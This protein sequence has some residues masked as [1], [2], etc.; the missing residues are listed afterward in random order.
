MARSGFVSE[1]ET[2]FRF[3][4]VSLWKM[5]TANWISG[6]LTQTLDGKMIDGGGDHTSCNQVLYIYLN[7]YISLRLEIIEGLQL[8]RMGRPES[9]FNA[10][11]LVKQGGVTSCAP[12]WHPIGFHLRI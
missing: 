6:I 7:I 9:M 8:T 1:R 4:V 3:T 2:G 12:A 5:M 11:V 10:N